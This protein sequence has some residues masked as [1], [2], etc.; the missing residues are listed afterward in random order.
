[1][2]KCGDRDAVPKSQVRSSAP[3]GGNTLLLDVTQQAKPIIPLF[4]ER[5]KTRTPQYDTRSM[6]VCI[7]RSP[8]FRQRRIDGLRPRKNG[9]SRARRPIPPKIMEGAAKASKQ[10]FSL[11]GV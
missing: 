7:D 10:S 8:D 9:H 5:A 11:A 4:G 3:T 1:M 6:L 2:G